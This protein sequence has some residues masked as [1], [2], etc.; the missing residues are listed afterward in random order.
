MRTEIQSAIAL[1]CGES[2]VYGTT[3]WIEEDRV[4]FETHGMV[5]PGD[6]VELRLELAGAYDSVRAEGRVIDAERRSK[7]G[8]LCCTVV[9]GRLDRADAASLEVWVEERSVSQSLG[10]GTSAGRERVSAAL[11]SSLRR[12]DPTRRAGLE[13]SLDGEMVTVRW[14]RPTDLLR[15]WETSLVHGRLEGRL[16]GPRPP[17]GTW[18][19]VRLVLP[20]GQVLAVRG[21]VEEARGPTFAVAFD[22]NQATAHKVRRAAGAA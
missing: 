19:T 18:M 5:Q 6:R 8:P 10:S 14:L 1:R 4:H 21:R 15:D 13:V 3:R 22:L 20:D 2:R 11:L 9:L 7:G 17:E 12:P 16:E